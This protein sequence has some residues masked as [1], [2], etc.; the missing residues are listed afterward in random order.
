MVYYHDLLGTQQEKKKDDDDNKN[1]R[2][3]HKMHYNY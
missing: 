3:I 1:W 2:V